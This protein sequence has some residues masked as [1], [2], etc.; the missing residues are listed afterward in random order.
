MQGAAQI[1]SSSLKYWSDVVAIELRNIEAMGLAQQKMLEGWGVLA[2]RQAEMAQGTLNRSLDPQGARIGSASTL[3]AA[4]IG[5]IEALKTAILEGQA[6]SNILSELAARSGGEVANV[7]QSRMIAA[8]DEFRV[9]LEQ[10][11][12]KQPAER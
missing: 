4:M 6:N 9:A 11:V 1:F 3:P 12:P 10:V 7:L 5:Q 2:Q 8:L